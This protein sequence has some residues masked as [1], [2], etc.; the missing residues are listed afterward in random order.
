MAVSVLQKVSEEGISGTQTVVGATTNAKKPNFN[1]TDTFAILHYAGAPSVERTAP[2]PTGLPVGGI[3]FQELNPSVSQHDKVYYSLYL[4]IVQS[5]ALAVGIMAAA[6]HP[7]RSKRTVLPLPFFTHYNPNGTGV[8]SGS[9]I[10]NYTIRGDV[11]LG[12][13]DVINGKSDLERRILPLQWAL[14]SAIIQL[15]CR[16]GVAGLPPIS[17]EGQYSIE[18]DEEEPL[19]IKLSG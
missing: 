6:G 11:G 8:M 10:L 7:P 18:T 9:T 16:G 3:E 2:Q 13:I 4:F 5:L 17:R 1:G 19:M 14:D 15:E 12:F